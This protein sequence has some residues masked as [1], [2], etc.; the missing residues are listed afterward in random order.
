MLL[1][2]RLAAGNT[3]KTG[4]FLMARPLVVAHQV[5]ANKAVR[6]LQAGLADLRQKY[7][8]VD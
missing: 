5:R 1:K 3:A 4:I 7:G 6:R 2:R 8:R